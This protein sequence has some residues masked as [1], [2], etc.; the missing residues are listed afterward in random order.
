[1]YSIASPYFVLN[2]KP[3]K[4]SEKKARLERQFADLYH[5]FLQ[6]VASMP[7]QKAASYEEEQ[8]LLALFSELHELKRE[9]ER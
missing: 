9:L 7:V 8:R 3:Q 1:M 5:L 2:D 6:K 4:E